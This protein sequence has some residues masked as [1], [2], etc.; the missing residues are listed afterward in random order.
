MK[1]WL[2]FSVFVFLLGIGVFFYLRQRLSQQSAT[3][4]LIFNFDTQRW[5]KYTYEDPVE[6]D[7]EAILSTS[8]NEEGLHNPAVFKGYFD[9]YDEN[10]QFE[11]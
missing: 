4:K 8:N 11:I 2:V 5:E 7:R 9:S 3:D 6:E 1:K 10:N